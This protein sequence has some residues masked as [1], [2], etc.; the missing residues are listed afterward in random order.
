LH[1]RALQPRT[2]APARVLSTA[3][4]DFRVILECPEFPEFEELDTSDI[5]DRAHY[6]FRGY[7]NEDGVLDYQYECRLPG[8]AGRTHS[9]DTYDIAIVARQ[10]GEL[11]RNNQFAGPST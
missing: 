2:E 9:D 11:A 1:V 5:L 6:L 4:T 7:I 3:R 10:R 8:I